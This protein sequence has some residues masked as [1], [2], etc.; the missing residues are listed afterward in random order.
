MSNTPV[1]ESTA[2]HL[3]PRGD[4]RVVPLVL[5][6]LLATAGI[7]GCLV[8]TALADLAI[9]TAIEGSPR[10]PSTG[11]TVTTHPDPYFVHSV[12]GIPVSTITVTAPDGSTLPVRLTT[13]AYGYGP[14]KKGLEVGWF[15][16]PAGAGLGDYRIAATPAAES[17]PITLAVTTFDVVGTNRL[18]TLGVVVLLV[19]NLGAAGVLVVWGARPAATH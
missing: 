15:E 8:I 12:D 17:T 11:F 1:P 9:T 18:R 16:V 14:H 2:T 3:R 5:A 6:A 4:R 19:V 13:H 10:G 7:L